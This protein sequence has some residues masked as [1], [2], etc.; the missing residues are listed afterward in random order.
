MANCIPQ[1]VKTNFRIPVQSSPVISSPVISDTHTILYHLILPIF[2]TLE[3]RIAEK[4]WRG[5]EKL[6]KLK[7]T[8]F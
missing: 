4:I 8:K 6:A 7:I 3:Y 2:A 5:I 1:C